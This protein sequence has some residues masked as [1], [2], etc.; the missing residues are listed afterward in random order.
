MSRWRGAAMLVLAVVGIG[1]ACVPMGRQF[2]RPTPTTFRLGESSAAEV[3]KQLGEPADQR[4]WARTD[5][6]LREPPT[7]VPTPFGGASVGGSMRE[8]KYR[9]SW[10]AGEAATSGVEPARNLELW[11]WNDK[12]VGYRGVSSFK[13]DSTTFDETK[14]TALTPWKSLRADVVKLLG[15]PSGLLGYP[16]TRNEDQQVLVYHGFEWDT[17]KRESRFTILYVLVNALG[18]V[19]DTRFDASSRPLPPP[20]P[21]GTST[22]VYI[23]PPPRRSR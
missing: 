14:A 8:M 13:E 16:L 20:V 4:A 12:L 3:T 22:P 2:V 23:S 15:E 6:L 1:A 10:R 17:S 5:N 21:T 7:P 19:E 18:I 9:Y 11:F